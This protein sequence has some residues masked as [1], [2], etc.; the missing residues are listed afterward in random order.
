M[1]KRIDGDDP[2]ADVVLV[3]ARSQNSGLEDLVSCDVSAISQPSERVP[4][5]RSR[6]LW[7]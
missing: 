2:V 1:I 7:P 3:V 5:N 4:S 6:S